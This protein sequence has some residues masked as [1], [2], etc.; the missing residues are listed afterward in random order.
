MKTT[1]KKF[2]LENHCYFK[3][4]VQCLTVLLILLELYPSSETTT[5]DLFLYMTEMSHFENFGS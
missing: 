5:D 4:H 3:V 2:N 1:Q